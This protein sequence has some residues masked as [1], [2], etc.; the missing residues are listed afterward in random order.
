[1]KLLAVPASILLFA[2]C[3]FGGQRAVARNQPGRASLSPAPSREAV[4]RKDLP[5]RLRS[6]IPRLMKEGEV[7][8]LSIALVR[9]AEIS[10][11]Q[12]FGVRSADTK[13]PVR[14]DTLFEAASLSK[15]VFAYAVLKLVDAGR[16]ELDKP[17]ASYL[18]EPYLQDDER[19]K[20]ITARM[21]LDHTTGFQNEVT[22]GRPLKIY[23]TPGEK[24][25]YSGEGYLY[26]QKVVERVTGEALDA[27]VGR[28]VFGPLGMTSS[29]YLCEDVYEARK[30]SGHD[31]SGAVAR[32]RRPAAARAYSGL[33]TTALDYARFVMAVMSGTGLK[34]ETAAQMLRGQV[35]LDESCFTCVERSAGRLSQA[36]SWGLGW[37]LERTGAGEA[38]W[39]WGDNNREFQ[40]FVMAYPKERLGVVIFTNSG[41]GLSI[42]PAIISQITGGVHPAFAWMGYEPY[43]SP[44]KLLFRDILARGG[45]AIS[46]YRESRRQ[47]AGALDEPQ[48]NGL[49]YL[50]LGKRRVEEAIE[51]FKMNVEDHPDSSNAYDSLGEAYMTR[52]DKE[53][54]VRNYRRSLELNRDNA[55]AA[56]MLRRLRGR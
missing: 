34:K 32:E 27:F 2:G 56:E 49:G 52:G 45:T 30:A 5:R 12:G 31:P 13:E 1:M 40:S 26:L 4:R 42:T 7:Q 19:V 16:L 50:L 36:L 6:I 38:A 35:R 55:N 29:C 44:A 8:G 53:L 24:F 9:G 23:F 48:V 15:P 22:P 47:G 54:A 17:L 28:T 37:A 18:P 20:L 46:E 3:L 10:W 43:D 41:N 33:H 14:D 21:V 25:S 39:H 11:H 51:V